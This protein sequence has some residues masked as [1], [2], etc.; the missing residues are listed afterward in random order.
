MIIASDKDEKLIRF[1]DVEWDQL[2][3]GE[4][5]ARPVAWSAGYFR[6]TVRLE[7]YPDPYET[8]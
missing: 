7:K 6:L 2:I 5:L 4:T 8:K 3:R 1:R